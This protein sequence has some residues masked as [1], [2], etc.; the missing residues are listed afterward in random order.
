MAANDSAPVRIIS[1]PA[2]YGKTSALLGWLGSATSSNRAVWI[3]LDETVVDRIAF[4]ALTLHQ[5][6]SAGLSMHED[7]VDALRQPREGTPFL[8]A[9]LAAQLEAVSP[10][11]IVV[12]AGA[13]RPEPAVI[14]D[15]LR[16]ATQVDSVQIVIASR[17]STQELI[18]DSLAPD[19]IVQFPSADLLFTVQEITASARRLGIELTGDEARSLHDSTAGWPSAVRSVLDPSQNRGLNGAMP[20]AAQIIESVRA[21]PGYDGLLVASL[22]DVVHRDDIDRLDSAA[23]VAPLLER[24][25]RTGLGFWDDSSQ[26]TFRL[27]PAARDALRAEFA[28]SDP[29]G[30]RDA[31]RE[32]AVRHLAQDTS[33]ALAHA[34]ESG[35]WELTARIS[36]RHL[37]SVTQR[38]GGTALSTVGIPPR[39][40]RDYPILR[41]MVALDDYSNGR[42]ARAVQGLTTLLAVTEGRHLMRRNGTL[43][44]IWLQALVVTSLR[45]LGRYELARTGLRRLERMIAHTPDPEGEVDEARSVLIRDGATTL[46]LAGHL[47]EAAELLDEAGADPLPNRPDIERARV[48]GM[49]A[50]VS[51]LRGDV[52]AAE[53]SLA[54]HDLLSLPVHFDTTYTAFAAM[55]AHALVNIERGELDTA[56]GFLS[57][58]DSHA[59]TT[60]MWPLLLRA[61]VLIAWERKGAPE[62]LLL[63]ERLAGSHTRGRSAHGPFA[64]H[65]VITLRVR[66]LLSMGRYAEARSALA[67]AP[68]ARSQRWS[69][70]RAHLEL[71][72]GEPER[73]SV[74]ALAALN[75]APS[76]RE[77]LALLVLA[78][79]ATQRVGDD[80]QAAAHRNAAVVLAQQHG[81]LLPFATVP[82]DEALAVASSAPELVAALRELRCYPSGASPSVSLTPRESVVLNHLLEGM[83]VAETAQSLSV[84]KNT[85]KTQVR[86][87]YRK[88]GVDNRSDAAA[89]ARL[90]RLI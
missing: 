87:V 74:I 51:A 39:A 78:A 58:T 52:R 63:L 26:R 13:Q 54:A 6:R 7:L 24:L 45:L 3:P 28:A 8:P 68:H 76:P 46:M 59:A 57:R 88:L 66:L 85:V 36:R 56:E 60:E 21:D 17:D 82:H 32:L 5:L 90:R 64:V 4:W 84:S 67:D 42:R 27:L 44:D 70:T 19:H 14:A 80:A 89:Q 49:R 12:D 10:L 15:L 77:H 37:L 33:V 48:L 47:Q 50:L 22:S 61:R 20:F 30:K 29:Q 55:V 18:G 23:P 40:Q 62:A 41:F 38:V 69:S 81:L 9:L 71:L 75:A 83:T 79:T 65:T 73:A 72:A 35:D 86:S 31:H 34:I 11:V 53:A 25:A 2:G 1:A 43:D 16:L